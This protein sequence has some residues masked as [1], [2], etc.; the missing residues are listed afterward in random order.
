MFDMK[1]VVKAKYQDEVTSA[2]L[3]GSL[4]ALKM[5]L[6]YLNDLMDGTSNQTSLFVNDAQR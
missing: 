4:L 3:R 5:F 2:V 6:I 1:T